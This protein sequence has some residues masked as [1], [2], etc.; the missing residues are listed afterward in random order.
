MIA[1]DYLMKFLIAILALLL[2]T[3]CLATT[4]HEYGLLVY[5][6]GERANAN[7]T[8][9]LWNDGLALAAKE[10]ADEQAAHDGNCPAHD[11]CDGTSWSKRVQ[12][13][14]AGWVA[15]GENAA[16]TIDDPRHAVGTWM[17][18]PVHREN[19]L[20][21]VFTEMGGA[22][23]RGATAF[24]DLWFTYQDFGSRGMISFWLYPKIIA[25]SAVNNRDGTYEFALNHFDDHPPIQVQAV[26][27]DSCVPLYL[28]KG[29]VK[30][31][32]YTGTYMVSGC[33]AV[34]FEVMEMDGKL[35]EWG[36]LFLNCAAAPI[37]VPQCSLR[38]GIQPTPTPVGEPL[39]V[40]VHYNRRKTIMSGYVYLPSPLG[41]FK[42]DSKVVSK[43]CVVKYGIG[44]KSKCGD[45]S[46]RMTPARIPRYR[47]QFEIP[48]R[49]PFPTWIIV[50][51]KSFRPV[52]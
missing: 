30:N 5:A 39:P 46:V 21:S 43:E 18:S 35:Q 2:S 36:P 13:Y 10:K 6:N 23:S 24:G 42:I 47:F 22:S 34:R 1:E 19:I 44:S 33:N 38:T 16:T 27:G 41:E 8:P 48:G 14:Y 37:E 49:V 15:L 17:N 3:P 31:G 51:G 50:G 40:K 25:G 20:N 11:A 29:T 45:F 32:M 26:V 7:V 12:K 9:L 28:N 4:N 52:Q